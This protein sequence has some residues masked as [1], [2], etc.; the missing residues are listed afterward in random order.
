MQGILESYEG[1]VVADADALWAIS[2]DKSILKKTKAAVVLTPHGG[3]AK[4]LG[5]DWESGRIAAAKAFAEEYGC[6]LV[7]KGHRTL[8]AYPDGSVSISTHGNAGMAKGG[9][10]DVLAGVLGAMLAQFE[11]KKAVDTALHL[12]ALLNPLHAVEP[13]QLCLSRSIANLNDKALLRAIT[14]IRLTHHTAT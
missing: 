9:S 1:T 3:E 7:L 4:K 14:N 2:L 11:H 10:G 13:Q 5:I 8:A 6:T 12:H